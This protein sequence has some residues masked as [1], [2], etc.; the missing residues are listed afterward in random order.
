M[1]DLAAR[2][3]GDVDAGVVE[4]QSRGAIQFDPRLLI[5]CLGGD[6]IRLGSS[7][8]RGILQDRG[9]GGESDFQLLLIGIER[10]AGKV[11]GVLGGLHSGAVLLHVKLRIADFDAYLI[12]QLMQPHLGLAIFE[13]RAHLVGLRFAIAQRDRKAEANALVR[14]GAVEQLVQRCTVAD[15]SWLWNG[16]GFSPGV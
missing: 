9:C 10:L 7:K 4:Q 14:R 2:G 8:D 11:D 6:Q 16:G 1:R 13:F 15:R 5:G 3:V 12:F